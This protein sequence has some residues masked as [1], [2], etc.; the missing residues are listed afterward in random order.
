MVGP[1]A[2]NTSVEAIMIIPETRR[3]TPDSVAPN[4]VNGRGHSREIKMIHLA[5]TKYSFDLARFTAPPGKPANHTN[6]SCWAFKQ[7]GKLNTEHKEK[8]SPSEDD[9]EEPRPPNTGGHKKFPPRS[10]R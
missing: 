10:K 7:A 5:W 2:T 9:D 3:S 4:P 6:R 8:G 1:D